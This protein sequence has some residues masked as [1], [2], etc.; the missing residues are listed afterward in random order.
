MGN[1]VSS[2]TTDDDGN[3]HHQYDDDKSKYR[4][5]PGSA[6]LE[7]TFCGSIDTTDPAEYTDISTVNRLLKRVE[8]APHLG[9]L[10]LSQQEGRRLPTPGS[11]L[12]QQSGRRRAT[13]LHPRLNR[14]LDRSNFA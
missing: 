4:S 7:K 13:P 2:S 6:M 9:N 10:L 8:V 14:W 12:E 3:H 1:K 5:F 11:A